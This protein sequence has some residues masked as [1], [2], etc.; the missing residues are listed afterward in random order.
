MPEGVLDTMPGQ[1]T[2]A[3]VAARRRAL[4][5]KARRQAA[6]AEREER[7]CGLLTRYFEARDHAAR[8]DHDAAVAVRELQQLLGTA[9]E[10]AALCGITAAAVRA[11]TASPQTAAGTGPDTAG[12]VKDSSRPQ[13]G[14][15]VAARDGQQLTGARP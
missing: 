9:A 2:S 6:A 8:H 13:S 1:T 3:R 5:V 14:I 15:P 10:T 7:I 11:V 4:E 12:G